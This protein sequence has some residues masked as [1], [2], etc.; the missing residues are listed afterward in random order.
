MPLLEVRNLEVK[1]PLRQGELSALRDV[2]LKVFENRAHQLAP[3]VRRRAR[4]VITENDRTVSAAGALEAGDLKAVGNLMVASH[5]SLRN[6]FEVSCPELNLLV[7]IALGVKGVY[8]ARLTG[9]GFGGSVVALVQSEAAADLD[10]AIA[11]RYGSL[12][13]RQA[14]VHVCK[15][16]EGVSE[17][18]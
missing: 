7:E 9:A 8:G 5:A 4:H 13:G 11:E 14:T 18:T 17:I 12:S 16:S 1:F 6:D 15:A 2:S 10:N 3:V